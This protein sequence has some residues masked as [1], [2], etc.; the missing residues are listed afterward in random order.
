M[1]WS[2]LCRNNGIQTN[3]LTFESGNDLSALKNGYSELNY[4][5]DFFSS[6]SSD[7][8]YLFISKYSPMEE[9]LNKEKEFMMK[10]I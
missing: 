2:Y 9:P 5:Y 1:Y 7:F 4:N 3:L 10:F 6:F 8:D